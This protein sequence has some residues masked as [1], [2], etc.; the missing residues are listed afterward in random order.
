MTQV[1]RRANLKNEPKTPPHLIVISKRRFFEGLQP[2]KAVLPVRRYIKLEKNITKIRV[3]TEGYQGEWSDH[4]DIAL[5]YVVGHDMKL[6]RAWATEDFPRVILEWN[7]KHLFVR[8]NIVPKYQTKVVRVRLVRKVNV[9]IKEAMN[10]AT[11]R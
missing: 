9:P 10:I 6:T 11:I 8:S 5:L 1:W 3:G 4:A 2:D 7:G